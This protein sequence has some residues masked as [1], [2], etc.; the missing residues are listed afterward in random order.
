VAVVICSYKTS[1]G[2]T[3]YDGN[4]YDMSDTGSIL[5]GAVLLVV[6]IMVP[7]RMAA[8]LLKVQYRLRVAPRSVVAMLSHAVLQA[9]PLRRL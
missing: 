7:Q 3:F 2:N 9:L 5:L 6:V 4:G 1:N 8:T